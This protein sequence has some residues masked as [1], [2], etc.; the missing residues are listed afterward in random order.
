MFNKIFAYFK[1]RKIIDEN[2][3]VISQRYR[4]RY[5]RKYGRLYT[6]LNITEDSKA[7]KTDE[8]SEVIIP[9]MY[10][11]DPSIKFQTSSGSDAYT[12]IPGSMPVFEPSMLVV[13]LTGSI[14][15]PIFL[16]EVPVEAVEIVPEIKNEVT[17][18]DSNEHT[19]YHGAP[20]IE[21]IPPPVPP[22]PS[23]PLHPE[24]RTANWKSR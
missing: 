11:Q 12:A 18:S 14:E 9:R 7:K 2:F 8:I 22:V 24:W 13:N 10:V 4:F 6:V 16:P 23:V 21:E 19:F 17:A 20:K 3:D 5:D 1:Y 15:E